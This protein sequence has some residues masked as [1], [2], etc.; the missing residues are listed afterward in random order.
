MII[1][2]LK[3]NYVVKSGKN[4]QAQNEIYADPPLGRRIDVNDSQWHILD[5]TGPTSELQPQSAT[6]RH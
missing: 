4:S 3:C 2:K 1:L 6:Y 5:I